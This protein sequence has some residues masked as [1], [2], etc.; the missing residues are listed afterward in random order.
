MEKI[1]VAQVIGKGNNGGVESMMINLYKFMDK[2]LIQCDFLIEN[3]CETINKEVVE[4]FGGKLIIIPSYKNPFKYMKVLKKIFAENKYDIVHSNMNTLSVF[5]LRAAKKAK[6]KHRIAHSHS[7]SNKKDII[8]NI[9]KNI[10][11]HFSKIYATDYVACGELAGRW[12]FGNKEFDKG[13]VLVINNGVKYDRFKFNSSTREQFRHELNI[14]DNF[15]LGNVGRLVE[16]K[17]QQFLISILAKIKQS[18]PNAKLVILGS[19]DLKEPLLEK[20]RLLGVKE[21]VLFFDKSTTPEKFYNAFDVFLL[22]SLYEGLPVS[23]IEAQISGLD[24][25]MSD[26]ISNDVII[27][28]GAQLLSIDFLDKWI[29]EIKT[30]SLNRK[31]K[32]ISV[33]NAKYDVKNS[34]LILQQHYLKLILF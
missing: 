25:L 30:I 12:L 22:P 15:V 21:D 31:I 6:I 11:K 10:L 2:D 23:A 18:I 8:R 27:T 14:S 13:N 34:A 16:Q 28:S 20:A 19:G 9:I 4:R 26:T 3:E 33:P 17:N 5:T 7:T 32:R 1:K 24:C 29:E